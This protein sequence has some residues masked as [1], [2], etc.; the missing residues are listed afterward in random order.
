MNNVKRIPQHVEPRQVQLEPWETTDQVQQ[1][2]P[3]WGYQQYRPSQYISVDANDPQQNALSPMGMLGRSLQNVFQM[4][5]GLLRDLDA[6]MSRLEQTHYQP[7]PAASPEKFYAQTWWALW[8]I[9][10]L[11]IGSALVVVVLLIFKN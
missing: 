4:Q 11:I 2:D 8:G 10:M 3:Y 9:L 6:R 1:Y 5:M 7:Q